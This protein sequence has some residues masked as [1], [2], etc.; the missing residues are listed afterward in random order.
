MGQFDLGARARA[1]AAVGV[2]VASGLFVVSFGPSPS[3]ADALLSSTHSSFLRATGNDGGPTPAAAPAPGPDDWPTYEHDL[4]RSGYNPGEH[5]LSVANVGQLAL[6]WKFV[7]GGPI[8]GAPIVVNGT[9]YVGSWD[10]FLYSLYASNGSVIWKKNLGQVT[11]SGCPW[12]SPRGVGASPTYSGG[13]LYDAGPSTLYKLDASNGTVV[14]HASI[15]VYLWS[16][17]VVYNGFVYEGVASG[18]DN[19]LI[20]GEL[21]QYYD[22]NGSLARVFYVVGSAGSGDL[23]GS[24]WSTP[25]V[26]I[27]R[28]VIWITT[29][30]EETCTCYSRGVVALNATT[31]KVLGNWTQ[32]YAGYDYD[33]GAGPT[34]MNDSAGHALILTTNKDGYTRTFNRTNVSASGWN[35]IWVHQTTTYPPFTHPTATSISPAAYDGRYAYVAGGG[36]TVA[37]HSVLGTVS[38]MYPGNG[39]YVWRTATPGVTIGGLSAA[40]GLVAA[41]VGGEYYSSSAGRYFGDNNSTLEVLDAA[42]GSV[43]FQYPIPLDLDGPTVFAE[44]MLLTGA[45]SANL[46]AWNLFPNASTTTGALYAFALPGGGGPSASFSMTPASGSAPLPVAFVGNATGGAAPY[47]FAWTFGDG[48]NGSGPNVTHTYAAG[49]YTVELTVTDSMN[50]TANATRHLPV[51]PSLSANTSAT[52]TAVRVGGTITY[53]VHVYGGTSPFRYVWTFSNNG[54]TA[55]YGPT[56]SAQYLAPGNVTVVTSVED[57]FGHLAFAYAN[58]SVVPPISAL[59]SVV[60]GVS[61]SGV[62]AEFVGTFTGGRAPFTSNWSFG[63]GTYANG[64][65]VTHL[66]LHPGTFEAQ[67]TVEDGV[68]LPA[69]ADV[70]VTVPYPLAVTARIVSTGASPS[71][72]TPNAPYSA[73]LA[74]NATGGNPP[75]TYL[76]SGAGV[77]SGASGPSVS[78]SFSQSMNRTVFVTVHDSRGRVA[79]ASVTVPAPVFPPCASNSAGLEWAVYAGIGLVFLIVLVVAILL[80]VR[81]RRR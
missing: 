2:L 44:G 10:G 31:L 72:T 15:G 68:S 65:T 36:T 69:T 77:A 3:G 14:W 5:N 47:S 34:L 53:T 11:D 48:S 24:I 23:G 4:G 66:Y 64:A 7:P 26:D 62:L 67:F 17:P 20:Q 60:T 19:P 52:P 32:P 8:S 30:N 16:S 41:A 13:F 27:A 18:C 40:N 21:R 75:Y 79:N 70:N 25:A 74:A 54:T 39:T 59:A 56:V 35:P 12:I 1:I 37:G 6:K 78:G 29:G 43:L 49:N 81:S 42:N 9:V 71:C 63:D 38:A 51:G 73:D 33:F 45:A 22:S 55:P 57:V 61:G 28:N 80:V 76:W 50:R 58:V 46:T